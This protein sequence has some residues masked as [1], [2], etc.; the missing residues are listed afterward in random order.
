[1]EEQLPAGQIPLTHILDSISNAVFLM[2]KKKEFL[3]LNTSAHPLI[4]GSTGCNTHEKAGDF[5]SNLGVD[6]AIVEGKE[7]STTALLDGSA[8]QVTVIPMAPK[9]HPDSVMVVVDDV[10][11]AG[12]LSR[13]FEEC[14]RETSM[15]KHILETAYDGLVVT[16]STG[17]ITMMS[18]AYKGFL[19]VTDQEVVGKHITD[20]VENTRL[21]IVAKTGVAELNDIQRIQGNHMVASRIPYT[22]DGKLAGVVGKV[23]FQDVDELGEINKKLETME[24]ELNRYRNEISKLHQ[25]RYC[26]DVIFTRNARMEALKSHAG[27]IAQ[28]DSNV[29]ILGESGTGKELFAHAIHQ[30]SNRSFQPF[31]RVNCAAIPENLL[32]SE[33]F[34]HEKGAFTGASSTK[35]GKFELANHGTIFLD[36]IGDMPLQMQAKILRVLQEGEVEHIGAS[37]PKRVDVRVIAATNKNLSEMVEK[38]TF[39]ED[40]LYRLNVFTLTIPPLKRRR[41]DIELIA[42]HTISALNRKMKRGV[43]GVSPKA[44]C[45][46]QA[47]PWPGNIRELK[48]VVE[49]AY[50]IMEGE[51][52]IQPWHLP[53][54]LR[55]GNINASQEP[56]KYILETMERKIITE[57][58]ILHSGNKTKTAAD[59]GISRVAL[60]KKLEKYS[61][62]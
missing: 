59:L 18:N 28:S 19:G 48:N 38:K 45:L 32:E 20:V 44:S 24:K 41:E 26:M 46:L 62:K 6:D 22:V 17:R 60:H 10:S 23:I 36:E 33:L 5:L 43:K 11:Q 40:L 49:R 47:Y 37:R 42:G 25:A 55:G 15:L 8:Y 12:E 3:Y 2:N 13:Q 14:Q 21:H 30:D 57:R 53:H 61:M 56:L 9:G 52:F 7:K 29:L 51:E 16:D 4:S 27:V 31:I 54:F 35:L 50:H 58:L 39:R 34:G 1:M